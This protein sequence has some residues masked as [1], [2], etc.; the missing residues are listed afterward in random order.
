MGVY[1]RIVMIMVLV[2]FVTSENLVVKSTM[3]LLRNIR[4]YTWSTAD[5]KTHKQID[6]ILI[7]SRWESIILIYEFAGEL[8]VIPNTVWCFAKFMER[9]VVSKQAAQKF[10]G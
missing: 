2:N 3:F 10:D 5:G 8:T 1:I 9:L 7:D 4:K 6:H